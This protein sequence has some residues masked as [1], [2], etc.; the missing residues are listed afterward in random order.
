MGW[1]PAKLL[2]YLCGWLADLHFAVSEGREGALGQADQCHDGTNHQHNLFQFFLFQTWLRKMINSMRESSVNMRRG[3]DVTQV[4]N[5][6]SEGSA[7]S[8]TNNLVVEV[9]SNSS[10]V[11]VFI[12]PMKE[13]ERIPRRTTTEK[14]STTTKREKTNEQQLITYKKYMTEDP[15]CTL[16]K[17]F[18][19]CRHF[20]SWKVDIF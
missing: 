7:S 4:R 6:S 11:N 15:D 2:S 19:T 9:L 10:Q 1:S 14:I 5:A 12:L 3:A 18:R 20:K 16:R 13:K 17:W 8:S